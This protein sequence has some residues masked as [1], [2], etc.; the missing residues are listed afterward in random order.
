MSRTK[1]MFDDIDTFA[2]E[3]DRT[4]VRDEE[5]SKATSQKITRTSLSTDISEDDLFGGT[6]GDASIKL[7]NEDKVSAESAWARVAEVGETQSQALAE[8]TVDEWIAEF[9]KEH[10][11]SFHGKYFVVYR[12][13]FIDGRAS[14]T[15]YADTA[16]VK[17]HANKVLLDP[18]PRDAPKLIKVSSLWLQR[19]SRRY[20]Q[21]VFD[22]SGGHDPRNYNMW[23]GFGVEQKAFDKNKIKLITED[24]LFENLCDG[25]RDLAEYLL[26]WLAHGVQ[27]PAIKPGVA[28]V[29]RGLQGTGKG[30][31]GRLML[32]CWGGH[33]ITV[34]HSKHL[35]GNFNDHLRTAV[36]VFSDEAQFVG[37]SQGNQVLKALITEDFGIFESKGVDADLRKNYVRV[38]MATNSDWVIN[39]GPDSRRYCV[40]DVPDRKRVDQANPENLAFW[41]DINTYINDT[42][43]AEFL[44]FLLKRDLRGFVP[45]LFPQTQALARQRAMSLPPIHAFLRHCLETCEIGHANWSSKSVSVAIGD[46][47]D[48]LVK[49]CNDHHLRTQELTAPK[50]GVELKKFGVDKVRRRGDGNQRSHH[51]VFPP[52]VEF[53][54][55]F[56][57]ALGLP[58]DDLLEA[59][60]TQECDE[61]LQRSDVHKEQTP[62]SLSADIV[63]LDLSNLDFDG[64][65]EAGH[66]GHG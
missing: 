57:E 23:R 48:K 44:D 66:P 20:E 26:N 55:T 6:G 34:S 25:N 8:K 27:N 61:P 51:Y 33:G 36:F 59:D 42:G 53:A 28:V 3:Q 56:V 1:V 17:F 64:T 29:L 4:D 14:L 18:T 12:E 41:N 43:A 46:M 21:L 54:K 19:T 24:L 10:F 63:D 16:F 40:I 11:V 13:T 60:D 35:T 49:Y 2:D 7:A 37:D 58:A 30:T 32:T 39:A 45:S 22:P 52:R 31:L 47:N 38:L 15:K 9:D 65:G 62:K 50:L 5:A